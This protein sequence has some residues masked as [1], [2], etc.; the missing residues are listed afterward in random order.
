[1]EKTNEKIVISDNDIWISNRFFWRTQAFRP[2]PKK[3]LK[4][5]KKYDAE[6][7]YIKENLLDGTKIKVP[8]IIYIPS[9]DTTF[10]NVT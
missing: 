3:K 4:K 10:T 9:T 7:V 5:L 8:K 6:V 1:M 2:N